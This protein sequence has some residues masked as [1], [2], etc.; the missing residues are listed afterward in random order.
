MHV[1]L[2]RHGHA[3]EPGLGRPDAARALT[4]EGRE[5]LERAS[6]TWRRLVTTPDLLLCSPLLR[7]RQ[8]AERFADAVRCHG[9]P[10]IEASLTPD[11]DVAATLAL[12]EAE[13]RSGTRSVAVVGHEPHLGYL[14]GLL[15][16][17]H[18]RLSIPLKKGMLVGLEME[19][20]AS[21][22]ANL[23]F[24]IAQRSAGELA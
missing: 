10:R 5:R 14:F 20:R 12:L 8:T 13:N 17:G 15:V 4:D 11:G 21:S 19:S 22:L 18:P 2:L 9:A 23:R 24:A 1:Y 6:P 16:T 3:E 7:A